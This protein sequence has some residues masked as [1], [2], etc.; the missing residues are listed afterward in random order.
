MTLKD[1]EG[2]KEREGEMTKREVEGGK[3]EGTE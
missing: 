1:V 3:L 2:V